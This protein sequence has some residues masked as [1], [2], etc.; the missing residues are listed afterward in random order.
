MIIKEIT[1]QNKL[2]MSLNDINF[3]Q[4]YLSCQTFIDYWPLLLGMRSP[5]RTDVHYNNLQELI[6]LAESI[7]VQ[8]DHF[9][10]QS[11]PDLLEVKNTLTN[12]CTQM[13]NLHK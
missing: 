12:Y 8:I 6:G 2:W 7:V 5:S 10:D 3:D 9:P 11:D 4:L 1:D 13:K